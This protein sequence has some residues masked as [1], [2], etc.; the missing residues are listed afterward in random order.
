MS[1]LQKEYDG[2]KKASSEKFSA[3]QKEFDELKAKHDHVVTELGSTQ[4]KV[5]E[6]EEQRKQLQ[7]A[8]EAETKRHNDDSAK[9]QK[10]LSDSQV[11]QQK[12]TSDHATELQNAKKETADLQSE[13]ELAD[14]RGKYDEANSKVSKAEEQLKSSQGVRYHMCL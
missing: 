13:S 7:E 3:Q 11:A 4:T 14:L 9:F 1:S 6:G 10:D 2:H 12:L 5:L 8:Q